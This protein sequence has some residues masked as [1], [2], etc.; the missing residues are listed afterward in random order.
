MLYPTNE[1]ETAVDASLATLRQAVGDESPASAVAGAITAVLGRWRRLERGSPYRNGALTESSVLLDGYCADD[2][3]RARPLLPERELLAW[4]IARQALADQLRGARAE[5]GLSVRQAAESASVAPS[6]LSELEGARRGLPSPAV[7]E[8]LDAALGTTA[9]EL[10]SEARAAAERF[11]T[12]RT[13]AA[14]ERP[15]RAA[16]DP[17]LVEATATLRQDP[18]LL[19]L[20]EY[21]RQLDPVGRRAVLALMRELTA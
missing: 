11:R 7:V 19:D 4:T 17:R 21:A 13:S 10:V 9:A 18:T 3:D 16:T 2:P 5:R 12:E 14:D 15:A 20:L 1:T 8:R 6:Y